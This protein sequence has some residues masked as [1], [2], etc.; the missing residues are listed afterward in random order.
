MGVGNKYKAVK[1]NNH[2]FIPSGIHQRHCVNMMNAI[3]RV[4]TS[5]EQVHHIDE[6]RSN[7]DMDNLMLFPNQ[8]T[9]KLFHRRLD[10]YKAIGNPDA[11]KCK[12]CKEW[13]IESNLMIKGN[14]AK[15]RDCYNKY[16]REY[17]LKYRA[18]KLIKR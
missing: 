5:C 12:H 6:D 9:H 8:S 2:K 18:N 4:L 13:D 10:A 15:H 11:R 7:D 1:V 17:M 3:G 14:E 16:Q